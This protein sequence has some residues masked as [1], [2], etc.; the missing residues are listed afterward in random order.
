VLPVSDAERDAAAAF[1]GRCEAAGLR[2]R[3][4]TEGSLG[5]RVRDGRLVPYTAVIGPAEASKDTVALRL[6]DGS[7]LDPVDA[8]AAVS[9]IGELVNAYSINLW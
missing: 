1:A 6:R 5:A 9:R 8:A 2:T 4:A 7:R 3:V